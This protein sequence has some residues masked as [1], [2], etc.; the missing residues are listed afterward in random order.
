MESEAVGKISSALTSDMARDFYA[1]VAIKAGDAT[2]TFVAAGLPML[3]GTSILTIEENN[4]FINNNKSKKVILTTYK[5]NK[6]P[7]VVD[8]RDPQNHTHSILKDT[9]G[10]LLYKK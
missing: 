5:N 8:F 6:D 3:L 4:D 9:N 7:E 10:K 1:E 2:T